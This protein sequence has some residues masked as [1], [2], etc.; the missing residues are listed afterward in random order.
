MTEMIIDIKE[1]K[2]LV[3]A[4]VKIDILYELFCTSSSSY[5]KEYMANLLL[6]IPAQEDKHDK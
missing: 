3:R 2:A 4:M 6:G 1:Y 5:E